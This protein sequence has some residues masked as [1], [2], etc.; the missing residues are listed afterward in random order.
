LIDTPRERT[1]WVKERAIAVGFDL[2]GVAD[3]APAATGGAYRD[4]VTEGMAGEMGYMARNPE[5]REDPRVVMPEA[6]SIVVV[7]LRYR[8]AEVASSGVA[9]TPQPPLPILGEGEPVGKQPVYS[10]LPGLGEG[11]GVRAG[12]QQ[13]QPPPLR[14]QVARYALGDDYHDVMLDRL[15]TL[16]AEIRA[17]YGAEVVGRPYVDTGPLLERDLAQRAGLGWWGKNTN[18]LHRDLG[19]YFF[20]G[21]LLLGLELEPDTPTTAHCGTCRRCLVACPTNAFV[22]PYVLDARRCISYLTIELKGP[23]PRELRPLM[24]TWIYGCDICQEVCPWN[25]KAPA[26]D[27][28]AFQPRGDLA[29]PELIPLLR[30]TDEE[31]RE[32][33]RGSPIKRTKRRG[34]LRNVAVALGN[35]G[36]PAAVPALREALS[37]PEPLVRGHAAWAL[38]RLGSPE[39]RAALEAAISKETD[40]Y[41]RSELA[42]A[43][44]AEFEPQIDADER[45]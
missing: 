38:G 5:R 26:T 36:D 21:A 6:R 28:P 3:A 25:R 35:I 8:P 34:L 16:L 14:G 31:F 7:A 4:W 33:F 15:R 29:A 37:D 42:A 43:V 23:I 17:R 10:P 30:I 19:S 18:L 39:A 41:V 2:A 9:L 13:R 44:G 22:A 40:A 1:A 32:R 20:L 11:Q 27:E 24:G 45:G 12:S